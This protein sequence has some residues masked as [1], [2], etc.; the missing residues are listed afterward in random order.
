MK[1]STAEISKLAAESLP[2]LIDEKL[3]RCWVLNVCCGLIAR[4][5]KC[6][7]IL[8]GKAARTFLKLKRTHC[9]HCNSMICATMN[10]PLFRS[11][12]TPAQFV[13]LAAFAPVE[14]DNQKM[15]QSLMALAKS[16]NG[17][18]EL[19]EALDV[20]PAVNFENRNLKDGDI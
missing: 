7:K 12:L 19:R 18:L 16:K 4:C 5:P 8:D 9:K 17:F 1:I 15:R 6:G 14:R 11:Y 20:G 10:S 13:L 2:L 3:L